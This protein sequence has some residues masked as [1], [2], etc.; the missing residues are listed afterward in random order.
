MPN[1]E[2]E[3]GTSKWKKAEKIVKDAFED[4]NR[5][6]VKEGRRIAKMVASEIDDSVEAP[7]GE[8][9]AFGE[10]NEAIEGLVNCIKKH[11]KGKAI[12]LPYGKEDDYLSWFGKIVAFFSSKERLLKEANAARLNLIR[13]LNES[14]KFWYKE[15][16]TIEAQARQIN[17]TVRWYSDRFNEMNEE[18]FK[19][20]EKILRLEK[21]NAELYVLLKVAKGIEELKSEKTNR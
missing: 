7:Q 8:K 15:W 16:G 19:L 3:K 2:R 18:G 1:K 21:D 20:R 17:S 12:V 13:T 10:Y 6:A 4:M 9:V 14:D 11:T 5:E